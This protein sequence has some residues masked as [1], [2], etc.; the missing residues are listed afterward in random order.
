MIQ[1]P[2]RDEMSAA[3]PTDTRFS[4]WRPGLDGVVEV[5]TLRGSEV[6]L[7]THFHGETQI[8][9]VLSGRRRFLIRGELTTLAPGQGTLIPAGVAH[10]SLAEPCGVAC[11]NVYAPTGEYDVAAMMH[12]AERLWSKT[13]HMRC[14][15]L[16]ALVREY[17]RGAGGY[18]PGISAVPADATC[19]EPVSRAA[20]RA[21]MSRE[22]FSRMFARH[23]GMPPH[24]FWLM[25]RL[26][27]ARELLRAG[28]GIAEVAAKAGFTDQSHLGRWFRRAFGVTPGRY[29]SGWPRSQTCQTWR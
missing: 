20:A 12:E 23:H 9:F 11:L 2:F 29:R 18:T 1:R 17:R 8:T 3:E 28:E 24:A 25:A 5:G 27:H 14:A 16:A 26:N 4:Y 6:G 22:G 13:G 7:P 21:G 15:E 19:P 10:R